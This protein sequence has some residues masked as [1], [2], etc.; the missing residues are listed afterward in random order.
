MEGQR[1]RATPA[2]RGHNAQLV[3]QASTRRLMDRPIARTA[4]QGSIRQQ[5]GLHQIRL[6][7]TVARASMA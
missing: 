7:R 4:G 6:V 3:R 2:S 5:K 1:A